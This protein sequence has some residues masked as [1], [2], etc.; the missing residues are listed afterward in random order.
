MGRALSGDLRS[1]VLKAS[2]EGMSARQAA[3]RFGVGVSSAIRWIARAKIGEQAPRPQGRRRASSLD[4]HEAFIVGLIEERKDITLN[5][6]VERLSAEHSVR[7]SPQRLERLASRPRLDIQKK[8][9]HALEQ[10]RPDVLKRRRDWF[11]GQ[12]D[13]DP[14]KLVFIDETGLSTKMARL[15]GRAPRGE[16]CRAGVPHGHW[17]TTTFTGALRLTGMTAPF[18]YDGAMNGNV[19]VAYVEQVLV[20]TLSEG[21]VVVMDNLPA[22]KAAGVRDAIEAAGASLLYLPPSSP[23]FN[24]IENAFSKLKALLRAKAERTIK[25]LWDAVGPLL[26]LFTPAECANYF[27]A[28]GYEPD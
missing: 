13:L 9:A 20:P 4:A 17:K 27:K 11:D 15:R 8:S 10:D 24:P 14:A 26:D 6:M 3:A 25:A 18:V 12:L 1:R 16:R 19:F 22:H 23:D 5:E 7:I 2:D 21:D 28:A